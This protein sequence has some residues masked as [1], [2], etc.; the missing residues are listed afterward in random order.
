MRN[1]FNLI[2]KEEQLEENEQFVETII[3]FHHFFE[4]Y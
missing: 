2:K 1:N 4:L 3:H